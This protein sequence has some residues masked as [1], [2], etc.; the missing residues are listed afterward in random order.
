MGR[1]QLTISP[2]ELIQL[3][4]LETDGGNEN[5]KNRLVAMTE[6]GIATGMGTETGTEIAVTGGTIDTMIPAIETGIDGMIRLTGIG[7]MTDATTPAA[8]QGGMIQEIG[9]PMRGIDDPMT[10]I[11]LG[12]DV[13]MI[14]QENFFLLVLRGMAETDLLIRHFQSLRLNRSVH[15]L[16][17]PRRL[18]RERQRPPRTTPMRQGIRGQAK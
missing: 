15:R 2:E 17:H 7:V 18:Q 5:E 4:S 9:V 12:I 14:L 11:E 3:R 8:V 16:P 1:L 13:E 6:I 10:G